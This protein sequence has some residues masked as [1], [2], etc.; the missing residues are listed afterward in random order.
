VT[1]VQTCALP[2]CRIVERLVQVP[3]SELILSG[4]IHKHK[5]WQLVCEDKGLRLV[6]L[7]GK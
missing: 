4:E 7:E 5:D 2:I 1:G 6:P 3:L